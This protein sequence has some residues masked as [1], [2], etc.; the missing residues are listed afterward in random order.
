MGEHP[1]G[2]TSPHGGSK[3]RGVKRHGADMIAV[4]RRKGPSFKFQPSLEGA[5]DLDIVKKQQ[6]LPTE[7][8]ISKRRATIRTGSASNFERTHD[9]RFLF[10]NVSHI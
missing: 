4:G 1:S 8:E 3:P 2:S 6:E 10:S 7:I 5:Y 9:T